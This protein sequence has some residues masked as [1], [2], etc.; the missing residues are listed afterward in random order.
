MNVT[1]LRMNGFRFHDWRDLFR[2]P[3]DAT[4]R[5]SRLSDESRT[6]GSRQSLVR[7]GPTIRI[8]RWPTALA[9]TTRWRRTLTLLLVVIMPIAAAATRLMAAFKTM[10]ATNQPTQPT[11]QPQPPITTAQTHPQHQKRR[12]L[13]RPI[14]HPHR[15]HQPLEP[16]QHPVLPLPGLRHNHQARLCHRKSPASCP[17]FA[18]Y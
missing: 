3:R 16:H 18:R 10:A 13:Y 9:I 6:M 2:F 1:R 5:R 15:H 14:H 7:A 17:T 4:P 8:Q 11:Q 12:P